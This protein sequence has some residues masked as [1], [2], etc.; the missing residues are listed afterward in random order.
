MTDFT[1]GQ[2]ATTNVTQSLRPNGATWGGSTRIAS[3]TSVTVTSTTKYRVRARVGDPKTGTVFN[4]PRTSIAAPNGEAYDE[5]AIAAKPKPRKIGEKPE[6]DHI[7]LDDPRIQW[8]FK[9]AARVAQNAGHCR[10]Y[11]ELCDKVGIPGRERDIYINTTINGLSISATI[12]ATSQKAAEALLK[13]KLA[14]TAAK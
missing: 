2:I 1:K 8:I 9:D 14:A 4:F 3:G 5:A 10:T 13:A 6:G 12:R 11:D 7:A